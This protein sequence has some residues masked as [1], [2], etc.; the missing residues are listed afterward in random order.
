MKV[1]AQLWPDFKHEG[2]KPYACC[3]IGPFPRDKTYSRVEF[4]SL[5]WGTYQMSYKEVLGYA[6]RKHENFSTYY[7]PPPY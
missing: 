1:E 3:V 4:D 7:L 6:D 2:T 5:G